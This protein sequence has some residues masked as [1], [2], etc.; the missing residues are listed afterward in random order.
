[1]CFIYLFY[2][3][4]EQIMKFEIPHIIVM[5]YLYYDQSW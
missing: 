1:M 2:A 4:F 5:D 3:Y